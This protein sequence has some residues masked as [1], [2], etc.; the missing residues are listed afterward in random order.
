MWLL[1]F[2]TEQVGSNCN[3]YNLYSWHAQSKYWLGWPS[4]LWLSMSFLSSSK[5]ILG[6]NKRRKPIHLLISVNQTSSVLN[7]L[8]NPIYS[9]PKIQPDTTV[10]L[11]D[12][13]AGHLTACY[14]QIQKTAGKK[15]EHLKVTWYN[16]TD[17]RK[18]DTYIIRC[19]QHLQCKM[20]QQLMK[21]KERH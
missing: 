17:I 15:Y 3:T 12:V 11:T 14:L 16:F 10:T 18:W 4:R 20:L 6:H 2:F 19:I 21:V 8:M 5:K 13:H 7:P 9:I 1:A